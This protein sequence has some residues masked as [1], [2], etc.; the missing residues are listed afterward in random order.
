MA[1][2]EYSDPLQVLGDVPET[3]LPAF[4]FDADQVDI[5]PVN[6]ASQL[7][8]VCDPRATLPLFLFTA[9]IWGKK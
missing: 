4:E 1:C 2:D 6:R 5:G 9:D 7:R 8:K 3:C